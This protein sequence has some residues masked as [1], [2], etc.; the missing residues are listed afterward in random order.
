VNSQLLPT[1]AGSDHKFSAVVAFGMPIANFSSGSIS[2]NLVETV[3][4]AQ[5]TA[6]PKVDFWELVW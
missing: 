2:E 5:R 1:N 4:L 6:L 3:Q